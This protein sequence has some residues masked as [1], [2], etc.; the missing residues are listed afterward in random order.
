MNAECRAILSYAKLHQIVGQML[1]FL[2][3][4]DVLLA[5]AIPGQYAKKELIRKFSVDLQELMTRESLENDKKVLTDRM[6]EFTQKV[7]EIAQ[8]VDK[9]AEKVDETVQKVDE[10]AQKVVET[11]QKVDETAC[12]IDEMKALVG[13]SDLTVTF[14]KVILDKTKQFV[15][16][17]WLFQQVE[18]YAKRVDTAR[19]LLILAAAGT[20]KSS[21]LAK[22]VKDESLEVHKRIL[23]FHFCDKSHADTLDVGLFVRHLLLSLQ[24]HA[25]IGEQFRDGLHGLEKEEKQYM[26]QMVSQGKGV[27]ASACLKIVLKVLNRIKR[28]AFTDVEDGHMLLVVD[29]LDESLHVES[30][31]TGKALSIAALLYNNLSHFPSWLRLLASSRYDPVAYGDFRRTVPI[32]SEEIYLDNANESSE[33]DINLYVQQQLQVLEVNFQTEAEKEEAARSIVVS[34]RCNFLYVELLFEEMKVDK[35]KISN[36]AMMIPRKLE[37]L[38][39][40]MLQRACEQISVGRQLSHHEAYQLLG[41]IISSSEPLDEGMLIGAL[42]WIYPDEANMPDR[43]KRRFKE[44]LRHLSP[45][46]KEEKKRGNTFFQIYHESIRDWLVTQKSECWD[47]RQGHAALFVLFARVTWLLDK[48]TEVKSSSSSSSLGG[49][50]EAVRQMLDR[51]TR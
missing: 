35:S 8:K 7:D 12:K 44:L 33:E 32:P 36:S 16:R 29:S 25:L 34:S 23:S 14:A 31:G 41:I 5:A 45:F 19:A 4:L 6:F 43:G 20:G 24:Q 13:P 49:D 2:S 38:F 3:E 21:V 40:G 46:L 27:D 15:G 10:T 47:A 22:M 11:A 28:D 39:E 37:D 42:Q 50:S 26:D 9:I 18:E 48:T 1:T 51:F 17:G 30:T